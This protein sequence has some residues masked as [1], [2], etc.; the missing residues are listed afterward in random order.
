MKT[1]R[2]NQR[3][4]PEGR[5]S[6]GNPF[7]VGTHRLFGG[8]SFERLLSSGKLQEPARSPCFAATE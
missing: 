2:M 3:L 4:W 6:V 1:A 8:A 5:D 7:L